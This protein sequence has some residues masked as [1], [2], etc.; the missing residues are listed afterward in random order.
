MDLKK[1]KRL[2][3][4]GWKVG[5]VKELLDL[6]EAEE[7]FIEIKLALARAF[8]DLREQFGTQAKTAKHL[9]S[10]Q[11]RVAKMEAGDR[12]VTLDLLVR[13]LLALGATQADVAK[14]FRPSTARTNKKA[15]P[16]R[17]TV[18]SRA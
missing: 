14:V 3:A 16:K 9:K 8:T 7:R 17:T 5:T 12:T 15:P 13:G 1:R 6:S 2:E 4:K 18:K 11:S 10:S